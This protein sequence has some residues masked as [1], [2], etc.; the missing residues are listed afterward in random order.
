VPSAPQQSMTMDITM[1]DL[2][3]AITIE[4]P[5]DRDVQTMHD[6]SLNG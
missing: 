6:L 5:P 2:D 3:K 4:L 1:Y